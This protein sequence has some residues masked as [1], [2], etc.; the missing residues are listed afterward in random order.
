MVSEKLN[1]IP[2]YKDC[3]LWLLLRFFF[4]FDFL[5]CEQDMPRCVGSGA[6]FVVVDVIYLSIGI[7][8]S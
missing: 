6:V 8:P 2:I 3:I 4:T 1:V 5:Q 7:Y